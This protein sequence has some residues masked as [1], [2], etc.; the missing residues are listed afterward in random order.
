M[1]QSAETSFHFFRLFDLAFFA[2]GATVCGALWLEGFITRSRLR[3]DE[4][5]GE[6]SQGAAMLLGAVLAC[7]LVGLTC[8]GVQQLLRSAIPQLTELIWSTPKSTPPP[9]LKYWFSELGPEACRELALYFWYKRTTCWNMAVA[10][11]VAAAL[12][13]YSIWSTRCTEKFL[14]IGFGIAVVC[15]FVWL[16]YDF[17]SG[18][19]AASV[20]SKSS[21]SINTGHICKPYPR[22]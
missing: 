11:F 4:I 22:R 20:A 12:H 17:E 2:P 8:H 3:L 18:R 10:V 19:N 5:N 15:L 16:G 9:P 1:A 6:A 21:P 7:Y 14:T 13:V